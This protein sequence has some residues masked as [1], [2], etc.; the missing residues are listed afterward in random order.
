LFQW[1][2]VHEL[3]GQMA[4]A[5]DFYR[6]SFARLP[7]SV[8]TV[9]HLA[10]ALTATGDAAA[11]NTLATAALAQNRHPALLALAGDVDEATREW[12]RYVKALPEAFSDHAA[13]FYLA[14]GKNPKRALELAR[15]NLANR[16]TLQ[17]RALVVEAALAA[18]DP[19]AAC[20]VVDPLLNAGTRAD[21]FT[22]WK[23]LGTCGR[24]ADA[25]RLGR[26][27]GI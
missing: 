26:E 16:D 9:E 24:K 20:A 4:V 19:T 2:R 1:G 21:R 10:G 6:A 23:A 25:D 5:R 27:L 3:D 12:E 15:A 13:R 14:A 8:E 7:G 18:G 22:A 11:A 17:A